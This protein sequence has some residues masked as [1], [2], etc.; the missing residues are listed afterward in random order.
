MR[1]HTSK[2]LNDALCTESCLKLTAKITTF[3]LSFFEFKVHVTVEY[4]KQVNI[5]ISSLYITP[6]TRFQ[7]GFT[8]VKPCKKRKRCSPDDLVS[9]ASQFR[10]FLNLP[11][12]S[13]KL[14]HVSWQAFDA[15]VSEHSRI[16]L[17]AWCL[18]VSNEVFFFDDGTDDVVFRPRYYTPSVFQNL[19]SLV[20]YGHVDII[21]QLLELEII[22]KKIRWIRFIIYGISGN[23]SQPTFDSSLDK[24]V[25]HLYPNSIYQLETHP[26][27]N[28][29][30]T[31]TMLPAN[32]KRPNAHLTGKC[33]CW[34]YAQQR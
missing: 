8:T 9:K 24:L 4:L 34:Y 13:L 28:E 19:T 27:H 12:K 7:A 33:T 25:R 23:I 22:S 6:L 16:E 30:K 26:S 5:P 3:L 32:A 10:P 17:L 1:F 20:L 2:T 11:I 14:H 15:M 31:K 21:S 18:P 29:A